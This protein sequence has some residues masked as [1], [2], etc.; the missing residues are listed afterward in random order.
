MLLFYS[1]KVEII[2]YKNRTCNFYKPNFYVFNVNVL[3]ADQ[4][5][6]RFC[7]NGNNQEVYRK[8]RQKLCGAEYRAPLWQLPFRFCRYWF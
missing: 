3:R 1:L 7:L 5:F 2:E 8:P 4:Q 6:Q